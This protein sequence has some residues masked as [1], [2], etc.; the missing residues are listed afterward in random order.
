M[1]IIGA[2]NGEFRWLSNFWPVSITCADGITYPS[3][4]HAY[5]AAKTVDLSIRREIAALKT[6]G[7][8]KRF[9]RKIKLR[10]DWETVKRGEMLAVLRLKF[11]DPLLR[12]KLIGTGDAH[13]IEGN[14]W[15]DTY[16]GVCNGQGQNV[17]GQLL[18]QVR[19]EIYW[20]DLV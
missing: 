5:M 8:A 11:Q 1:K 19:S 14:T 10:A 16:W 15:G 7:D 4:E 17:L 2:F 6:P 20:D 3:S 18:M 9:S 12:M 13:L